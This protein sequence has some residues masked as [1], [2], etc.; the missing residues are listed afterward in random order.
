MT[1]DLMALLAG[2]VVILFVE[3]LTGHILRAR[4]APDGSNA[5]IENLN[6]RI[7]AWWA[8]VV[9]L[10]LAL[11]AGR[12]GV[13]LLFAV[14]SFAALR[15]F[16]TLTTKTPADHGALLASF[17]IVLPVQYW[18]VGTDWYGL[19]SVFIPVY[20]FLFL[21]A[22]SALQGKPERF[23]YR[24]AETQ[25]AL[26]VCVYC[27]SHVPALLSLQIPGFEGRNVI[28]IA[29][30]I[31]VVQFSD[32]MQYVWGKLVGR[33]KIAPDLSPSKTW[34]GLIGGAATAVAIGTSLWWMTPFSVL[35]AACVALVVT[36]MGFL[37]GLVM[38]AIKRDKGVKD[39]GHLIAGHGGFVDRL[40]SVIFAAPIYFHLIRYFWATG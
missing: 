39:W 3:T 14:L 27:V 11:V 18:L 23:L 7:A 1:P 5:M 21:P 38:S 19:Y 17:F 30:L 26:M 10:T 4:I 8:M 24:V 36:L 29:W 28:L 2:V 33:R 13:V 12:A 15:E 6:A 20:A 16:L 40:D 9:L 34:E 22:V 32:V 31:F 37:G 25:W 35:Q